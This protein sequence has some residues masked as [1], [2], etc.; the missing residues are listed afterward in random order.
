MYEQSTIL[1]QQATQAATAASQIASNLVDNVSSKHLPIQRKLAVGAADDPLEHEA[2]AMADRVVRMPFSSTQHAIQRHCNHCEEEENDGIAQRKPLVSFIQKKEN[3]QGE[4]AASDAVTNQINATKGGGSGMDNQTLSFMESRFGTSFQD[5]RIHTGG[6][7]TELSQ[8]LN[9]KAFT[10]AN[11]VYFNQNKYAPNTTDGKHLLAHELTHTVQQNH[12]SIQPM[13]IQRDLA[14]EPTDALAEGREL[15]A[16]Q[17]RSAI[18]WNQAAF[19]DADEVSLLRDVL[20]ISAEPATVNEDFVNAIVRYQANFGMT[21][22]GKIGAATALRLANE[23]RAEGTFMGADADVASGTEM[24]LNPAERR[25]RLRSR[26]VA[27]LGNL[28]HQGF[29]GARDNPTGVV[30]VR[31]GFTNP[32][33]TDLTNAIGVNYTGR[34][35]DNSRWLQFAFR[36][37]STIDPVTRRRIYRAGS[38][39]TSAGTGRP[40]S[41]GTTF[42]WAV[43]TVPA[44]GSMYYDAGFTAERVLGAHTEIF[45]QPNG[46]NNQAETYAASFATRPASIRMINGFDT[47]LVVND[48]SV[49]YHVRWN[50]YFNFNGTTSPIPDVAGTYEVLSAGAASRLPADRKAALDAAFPTNT[51]P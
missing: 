44:T 43:D 12:S 36:Q 9:A 25:M 27:R 51:V 21:Q 49:I 45:D 37:M 32:G 24:A 38:T 4:A 7:A 48:N 20:G 11:N 26:V 50:I 3:G 23:L 18:R 39:T 28:Q 14:V 46:W 41:D 1:P 47:Y 35:A 34:N 31:T 40:Y 13:L 29:I 10:V 15:T 33:R 2:D 22:D 16:T 30:T 6:Y 42:R 8:Q 5:V 19:S 17:M